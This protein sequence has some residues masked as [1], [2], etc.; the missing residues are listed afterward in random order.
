M[1]EAVE[2]NRHE[3]R[4]SVLVMRASMGARVLVP[5]YLRGK[6]QHRT[7]VPSRSMHWPPLLYYFS[8]TQYHKESTLYVQ[9]D[10]MFMLAAA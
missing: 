6:D 4:S 9:R 1:L 2:A 8:Y 5:L 3:P 10:E 7:E